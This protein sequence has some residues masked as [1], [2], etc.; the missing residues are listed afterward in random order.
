ME[1][2]PSR[3]DFQRGESK[4]RRDPVKC[5]SHWPEQLQGGEELKSAP[6]RPPEQDLLVRWSRAFRCH[7]RPPPPPSA[8]AAGSAWAWA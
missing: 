1:P 7:P 4:D 8:G 6:P 5:S 2:P 3:R